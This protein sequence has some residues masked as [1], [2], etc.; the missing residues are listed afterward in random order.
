MEKLFESFDHECATTYVDKDNVKL[1]IS[2]AKGFSEFDP[3][4]DAQFSDVFERADN[5]MY[6]NKRIMKSSRN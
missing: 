5:E 3:E 1:P 2:I 4:K 6:K